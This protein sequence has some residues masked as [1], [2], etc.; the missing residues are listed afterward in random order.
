MSTV[1]KETPLLIPLQAMR[2]LL[3]AA[4]AVPIIR[5]MKDKW[6]E[7]GLAV[8]ALFAVTNA[9]LLIPNPLMPKD[10]RMVHLLETESSNFLFGWL[11][12]LV[13]NGW[14]NQQGLRHRFRGNTQTS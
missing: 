7:A 14:R 10:V 3:W 13:L 4:I 2:A 12:V 6:W 5:M 9:Q 1:I 11:T 8:A